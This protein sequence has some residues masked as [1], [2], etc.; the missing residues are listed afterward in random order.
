MVGFFWPYYVAKMQDA[1]ARRAAA[2]FGCLVS[3]WAVIIMLCLAA[4]FVI[5]FRHEAELLWPMLL[6]FTLTLLARR[7]ALGPF[8]TWELCALSLLISYSC[9]IGFIYG[10]IGPWHWI[11]DYLSRR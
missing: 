4:Y 5:A 3:I 1:P 9:L 8:K 11:E 6:L 7:H 2:L 10:L